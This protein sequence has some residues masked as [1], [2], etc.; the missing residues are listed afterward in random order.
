MTGRSAAD[1]ALNAAFCTR[2]ASYSVTAWTKDGRDIIVHANAAKE[3]FLQSIKLLSRCLRQIKKNMH[4]DCERLGFKTQS[5]KL[6][7][8]KRPNKLLLQS[9]NS[10]KAK[11]ETES[12]C[13]QLDKGFVWR[14]RKLHDRCAGYQRYISFL[15]T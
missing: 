2:S 7:C 5:A 14:C 1:R 10:R 3:C 11:K 13:L 9:E 6:L 12:A 15:W 8:K 4:Y